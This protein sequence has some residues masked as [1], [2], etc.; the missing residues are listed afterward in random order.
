MTYLLKPC[1]TC[2]VATLHKSH[3]GYRTDCLTESALW[4]YE[5]R[6]GRAIPAVSG[7]AIRIDP[8]GGPDLILKDVNE[9]FRLP[10][11]IG[12][13]SAV[14]P[15]AAVRFKGRTVVNQGYVTDVR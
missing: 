13:V 5:P 6:A 8:N 15:D 2:K 7:F 4:N 12:P 9:R 11:G 14:G 3:S 10:S 1:S